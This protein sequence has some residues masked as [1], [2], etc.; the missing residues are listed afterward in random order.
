MHGHGRG[1]FVSAS[2]RTHPELA[3]Q[4]SAM[5]TS[6]PASTSPAELEL[7][8]P[9]PRSVEPR[10][11]VWRLPQRVTLACPRG[12]RPSAGLEWLGQALLERG[13]RL[14]ESAD[15][16]ARARVSL[17]LDAGLEHERYTLHVTDERVLITGGGA[18]ALQHGLAT[19]T[20]L[21]QLAPG[22]AGQLSLGQLAIDDAPDFAARGVLLDV[23]RD[24]VPTQ[25]T[26]RLLIDRLARWK[27][28]QLQLYVEHTFAYAGHEAV[29]RDASPLTPAE[30]RELDTYAAARQIEL[31]PNQ[32]SFGHLSRWLVHE[33]YRALAECPGGFEHPANW[34]GEPYGL[35]ATD[36]RSLELLEGLYDQLLPCFTSARFNVGLDE[37]I[38]LGRCR[39]RA[40]CEERGSGRVYLEFLQAV[41]ARVEAR[42]KRMMF[43]GDIIVQHP[44]L[45]GELPRSAIAL[46]WGYEADHPWAEH[47]ARFASAG[48]D[49]YVCPGTSSWSSLAGRSENAILNLAR[50]AEQGK[51]AG[52]AGLLTTDWGDHGHLQPLPVSY[53]GLLLGAGFGWNAGEAQRAHELDVPRLLDQHAFGD[54]AGALGRVVHD[55]GNAYREVGSLR[56]NSSVLFWSLIKP[57]RLF[58]PSG[59]TRESLEHTLAY[60]ERVCEPLASARPAAP[61]GP[62]VLAELGWV[63]DA[64][65][66]ACR[67]GS[68]RAAASGGDQ[69]AS[70]ARSA[71]LALAHELGELIERQRTLWLA[72]SRPGGLAD[73]LGRLERL[74]ELLRS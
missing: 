74:R 66:F 49:F 56:A 26:L 20:Q 19:L 54:R 50:A 63:R 51:A 31:V 34:S 1:L 3:E 48:L 59:V 5:N 9:R 42:G 44:E 29:W 14:E 69:I 61:E 40:A 21:V 41:H 33:P 62:L 23:S 55:L 22:D 7:L 13:H 8:W 11:G 24:R 18:A 36:P 37:T 71:R 15:G 47:L 65:R 10:G 38:D 57:E 60:I 46:E 58:A 16:E 25:A 2:P 68:A 4:S 45:I 28:N 30:L 12:V 72:R 67:L 35:C 53:L 27:V 52:A 17:R 6:T 32:N 39:S 43:W 73:S 70:I 64:L